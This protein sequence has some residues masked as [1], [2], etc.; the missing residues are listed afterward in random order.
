MSSLEKLLK[1]YDN[2]SPYVGGDTAKFLRR[3]KV[4]CETF[5]SIGTIDLAALVRFSDA[6][7]GVVGILDHDDEL[8]NAQ[9]ILDAC[10]EDRPGF[11]GE[12]GP[13]FLKVAEE[14]FYSDEERTT[15][16]VWR[17]SAAASLSIAYLRPKL[18]FFQRM[19]S[20]EWQ[21]SH[22]LRDFAHKWL[23]SAY[24]KANPKPDVVYVDNTITKV[25]TAPSPM[26]VPS[27]RGF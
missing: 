13:Q 14:V 16:N 26:G 7:S 22:D 20:V 4:V 3:A 25:T 19:A 10:D 17:L 11:L 23:K 1:S 21:R 18:G 6:V 8:D 24:R 27:Y 9:A 2:G 15:D 12:A 5:E